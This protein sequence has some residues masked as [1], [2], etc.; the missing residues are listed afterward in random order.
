VLRWA[1]EFEKFGIS[2]PWRF[3]RD[4]TDACGVWF[5]S[6]C[7]FLSWRVFFS[8]FIYLFYLFIFPI[9]LSGEDFG[10]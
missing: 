10:P 4:G 3:P 7:F 9:V 6:R 8:S 5:E 1:D 2:E